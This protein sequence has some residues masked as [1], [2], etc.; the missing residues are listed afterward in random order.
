MEA[1]A[2]G[3][4]GAPGSDTVPRARRVREVGDFPAGPVIFRD[5]IFRDR[6]AG[7]RAAT[8]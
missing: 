6:G 7:T 3:D 2:L 4:I 8:R 5:P 1:W